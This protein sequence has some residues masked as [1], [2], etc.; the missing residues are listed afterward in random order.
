VTEGATQSLAGRHAASVFLAFAFAYFMSALLRAV[1]ATLAPVFSVELGLGAG[2]LGLLAGT[3]F[4]GFAIMQLPLGMALDRYGPKRVLQGLL[5]LAVIGCV[6]FALARNLAQL[7]VARLMIGAGVAACLMAPLTY[8]RHTFTPALQLRANS[9]MLMTGSLGMLASTVPVQWLLPVTGWRG[10]FGAAAVLLLLAMAT[11][12][13]RVGK[14]EQRSPADTGASAL[15]GY[16][17]V[18]AHPAFVR[19]APLGFFVYGGMIAL[20]ALWIGPWLTN[21]GGR[22][23]AEAAQGLFIVNLS[24][25]LAFLGWGA[26]MPRINHLGWS[27]E[28]LIAAAWPLGAICLAL[29]V[30]QGPAAG[31]L[32]WAL[33][34]VLTSV[35]TLSQPAIGQAFPAA[36]A[37]RALSAFNLMI[38]AGVFAMQ[39][40][41]GLL[42]DALRRA[43]ADPTLAYRAT[44]GC[45]LA[46]CVLSFLWLNT[47]RRLRHR[48]EN[49]A[50]PR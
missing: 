35:V 40:G 41:I 9:W 20:Q 27:G 26:V 2:Q 18:F 28:R 34:C 6:G 42:I 32:L 13:L 33:W 25:L 14:F 44:F 3:Y 45:F 10:L 19:M 21:V 29:I 15:Q 36:L 7:L 38:F 5:T 24:M 11:V 23:P 49:S 16:R 31:A 22:T 12:Q 8:Y 50:R 47:L 43:G 30:W 46:G 1:T 17:S 37:G 48:V 4:F 39:W